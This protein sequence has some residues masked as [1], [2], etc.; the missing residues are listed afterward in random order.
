MKKLV[1]EN[2]KVGIEEMVDTFS[3]GPSLKRALD[4]MKTMS[5]EPKQK[6]QS[7]ERVSVGL[8]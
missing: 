6:K 2:E 8:T 5:L 3:L 1:S 7:L 4:K